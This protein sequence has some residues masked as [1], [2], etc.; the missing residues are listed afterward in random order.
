[1]SWLSFLRIAHPSKIP[2]AVTRFHTSRPV[3]GSLRVN[4]HCSF[5]ARCSST[6]DINHLKNVSPSMCNVVLQRSAST[7]EILP[8]KKPL[9]SI[10]VPIPNP[11]K[12]PPNAYSLFCKESYDKAKESVSV[13]D[14]NPQK[15]MANL[16]KMWNSLS[17]SEANMFKLKAK[18]LQEKY[19]VAKAEWEAN[20]SP[21]QEEALL[22]QKEEHSEALKEKKLKKVF[23]ETEKPERVKRVLAINLMDIEDVDVPEGGNQ[24]EKFTRQVQR[25]TEL[26][27]S[28]PENEK[29]VLK[30][31]ANQQNKNANV[32]YEKKLAAWVQKMFDEHRMDIVTKPEAKVALEQLGMPSRN[33]AALQLFMMS[34]LGKE[35]GVTVVTAKTIF[36]KLSNAQRES[37]T[38]QAMEDKDRYQQEWQDWMGKMESKGL[39]SY[40]EALLGKNRTKH[41]A[42]KVGRKSTSKG[43]KKKG[44]GKKKSTKK[45]PKKSST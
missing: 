10:E 42:K 37:F 12:R 23:K 39:K 5:S 9:S 8:A 17:E 1:M 15:V 32:N 24:K 2:T 4:L 11:P 6:L 22:H 33:K 30:E 16:G 13:E 35:K 19:K 36:D 45:T 40:A 27:N 25:K 21:L 44:R 29:E 7:S 41:T 34:E 14:Q 3:F 28:L 18:E 26:W 43:K 20:L 38:H 31:Q